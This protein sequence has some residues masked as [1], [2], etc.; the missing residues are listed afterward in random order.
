MCLKSK[1][2][3]RLIWL[4]VFVNSSHNTLGKTMCQPQSLICYYKWQNHNHTKQHQNLNVTVTT[5]TLS[6]TPLNFIQISH[7]FLPITPTYCSF[8]KT[9]RFKPVCVCVSVCVCV[10]VSVCVW[11]S[12]WKAGEVRET[13]SWERGEGWKE[14]WGEGNSEGARPCAARHTDL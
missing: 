4:L 12:M 6:N 1:L 10:C 8:Y 7:C 11:V 14:L 9:P 5:T 3:H 13:S 2:Q